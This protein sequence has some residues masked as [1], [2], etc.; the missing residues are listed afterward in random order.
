MNI[1]IAS[2]NMWSLFHFVV[3]RCGKSADRRQILDASKWPCDLGQVI[4]FSVP[5]GLPGAPNAYQGAY[6][7]GPEKI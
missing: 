3:L 4:N 7:K 6:E 5:Q 1:G 2:K